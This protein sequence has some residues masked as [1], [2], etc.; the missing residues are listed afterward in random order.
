MLEGTEASGGYLVED[1][2]G[3]LL[4]NGILRESAVMSL[5]NVRRTN[6][7]KERYPIYAGRPTV[8][9]VA[10]GAE[11][12]VTGAE[13]SEVS[14]DIKKFAT[15]VPFTEEMLEDARI[16]PVGPVDVDV[17]AAFADALDSHA[18]GRN[19]AGT[20]VGTFNNELSETTSTV[21]LGTGGDA[22]AVA[23]SAAM[24]TIEGNGYTPSGIVLSTDARQ[25]MR[26]RRD[27]VNTSMPLF[28]NG[29]VRETDALYGLPIRYTTNL[30]SFA[31][32]AA[33]GRVV[34]VVGDFSGAYF[35]VRRDIR[36]DATGIA[37][38]NVGGTQHNLW[39]RNEM[40]FLW[41]MRVGFFAHD[42]N[43]RFVAITNAA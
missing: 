43:R 5:A 26:D 39:Q 21:E 40:A 18:L 6:T 38:V 37:T 9:V 23:V 8:A 15:I 32:T 13:F 34:G 22:L 12:P 36:R 25:Y 41:E 31:G 16:D 29:F 30:Q 4:I 3:E 24:G 35:V 14:V 17:R 28:T 10:E 7:N 27:A 42:M 11:K 33:A 20:I 1:A 2:V 19:A